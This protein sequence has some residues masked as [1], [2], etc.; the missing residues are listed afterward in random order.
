LWNKI[1]MKNYLV[2]L[3]RYSIRPRSM[4]QL[5]AAV[6][7]ALRKG[8]SQTTITMSI[9]TSSPPVFRPH[10]PASRHLGIYYDVVIQ[11]PYDIIFTYPLGARQGVNLG[12][13]VNEAVNLCIPRWLPFGK[14]ATK[15]TCRLVKRFNS[16]L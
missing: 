6:G 3:F 4:V 16:I 15:C 13:C 9:Q 10:P 8:I 7:H 2:K 14:R 12:P 11:R 1:K 5:R